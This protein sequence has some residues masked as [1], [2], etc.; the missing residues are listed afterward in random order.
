LFFL[1]PC[2]ATDLVVRSAGENPD[3]SSLRSSE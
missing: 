3:S 1:N 2:A